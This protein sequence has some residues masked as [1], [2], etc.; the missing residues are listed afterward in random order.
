[1]LPGFIV[2]WNITSK[3]SIFV[4]VTVMQRHPLLV[5]LWFQISIRGLI[6]A[7]QISDTCHTHPY[8]T[9]MHT[10]TW[11]VSNLTAVP[12]KW[13]DNPYLYYF[14]VVGAGAGN[15]WPYPPA[16]LTA[17]PVQV[18]SGL[19]V[20]GLGHKYGELNQCIYSMGSVQ[21]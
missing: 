15:L 10:Y 20:T 4:L 11:Y 18:G 7:Y 6:S 1:M 9:Y 13:Q 17:D 12:K 2:D 14:I 3:D 16:W 19:L 5:T 8:H 21:V